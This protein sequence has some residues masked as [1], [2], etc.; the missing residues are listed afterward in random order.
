MLLGSGIEQ[1]RI[2]HELEIDIH[3]PSV[4]LGA[5]CVSAQP[6]KSIGNSA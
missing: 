1:L 5:F 6:K 4:V 3:H 2:E